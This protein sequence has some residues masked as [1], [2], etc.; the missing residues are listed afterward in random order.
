MTKKVVKVVILHTVLCQ[1]CSSCLSV[2][3]FS[4]RIPAFGSNKSENTSKLLVPSGVS[5]CCS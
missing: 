5:L 4:I 2:T 1:Q 3:V